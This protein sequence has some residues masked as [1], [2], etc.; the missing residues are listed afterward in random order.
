MG[1]TVDLGFDYLKASEVQFILEEKLQQKIEYQQ[2]PLAL[3]YEQ[4]ET[5]AKLIDMIER[6]GYNPIDYTSLRI[7]HPKPLSLAQWMDEEGTKKII[8][9]K[10]LG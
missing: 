4:S 2:V 7:W 3:L 9:L 5:F 8:A 10:E 6:D 1:K